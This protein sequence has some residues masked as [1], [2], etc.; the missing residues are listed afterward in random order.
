MT[1]LRAFDW[2]NDAAAKSELPSNSLPMNTLSKHLNKV[3]RQ[4]VYH[5]NHRQNNSAKYI[6][7]PIIPLHVSFEN[8]EPYDST[9]DIVNVKLRIWDNSWNTSA[10][11]PLKHSV[12]EHPSSTLVV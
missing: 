11:K 9:K 1:S 8:L 12:V 6:L 2:E 3:I 4:S 7:I 10:Y 5:K